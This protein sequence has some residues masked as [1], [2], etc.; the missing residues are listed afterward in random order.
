MIS[1]P[2]KAFEEALSIMREGGSELDSQAIGN[3]LRAKAERAI[4]EG[5]KLTR[6]KKGLGAN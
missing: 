2:R 5:H 1:K 4:S 3:L 6:S